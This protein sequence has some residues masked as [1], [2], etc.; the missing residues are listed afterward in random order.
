MC[1][2]LI[3]RELTIVLTPERL[4]KEARI[5]EDGLGSIC[6]TKLTM[7]MPSSERMDA[8]QPACTHQGSQA[9]CIL[10][11]H[12]VTLTGNVL[13]GLRTESI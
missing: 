6:R 3:H 11:Q 7:Y 4:Q 1:A 8:L 12:S 5:A 2:A 10:L 9:A 13:T